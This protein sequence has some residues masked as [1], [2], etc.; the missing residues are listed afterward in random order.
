MYFSRLKISSS[1]FVAG[2]VF[3]IDCEEPYDTI[4]I[5]NTTII[6]PNYPET[7]GWDRQCQVTLSFTAKV[8]IRFEDFNVYNHYSNCSYG[9]LEVRDGNSAN[10]PMIGDRLCGYTIPDP[11]KST[12]TSITFVFMSYDQG[13]GRGFR[14]ITDLGKS[15]CQ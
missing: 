3:V 13:Y 14:I 2:N 1:I 8:S 10:S 7:Y 6:S 5:P 12:G 9:W 4:E 11:M 15:F